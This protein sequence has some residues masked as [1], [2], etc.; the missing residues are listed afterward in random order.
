MKQEPEQ[1]RSAQRELIQR[2][3]GE[4]EHGPRGRVLSVR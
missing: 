1:W 2:L 4:L 3:P